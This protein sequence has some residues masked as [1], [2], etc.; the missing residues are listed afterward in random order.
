MGLGM[1]IRCPVVMMLKISS[2]LINLDSKFAKCGCQL[3]EFMG[4]LCRHILV[5]FQAKGNVQIPNHFILHHWTKDG[6]KGIEVNY[7]GSNFTS[8]STTPR[9]LRRIH[10]QQS[11]ILVNIAEESEELF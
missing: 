10:A 1:S 4:I 6:N 9:I 11:N 7:T 5:I 3:H 8:Q 2:L